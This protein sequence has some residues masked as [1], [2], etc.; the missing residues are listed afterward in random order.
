MKKITT[1]LAVAAAVTA[2]SLMPV[3]VAKA[4]PANMI[5]LEITPVC[6]MAADSAT[7]WNVVNKNADP[8]HIVWNALNHGKT[9]TFDASAGKS[10]F[11]SYFDA[12]DPNNTTQFKSGVDTT[13][14]NA[15]KEACKDGDIIA[16]PA[17]NGNGNGTTAPITPTDN[18][19]GKGADT[20]VAA[21]VASQTKEAQL[22]DTGAEQVLPYGI[23]A[24][25]A[26]VTATATVLVRKNIL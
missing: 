10:Q 1:I 21:P 13:Q 7:Y 16:S 4:T 2:G 25:I 22:A 18:N 26:T 15:Q 24:I 14:T 3:S 5:P 8:V 19:S 12:T 23:A 11:T 6:S 9:G 17:G 20:S